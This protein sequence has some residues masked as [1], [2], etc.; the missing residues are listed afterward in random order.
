M[1]G[2]GVSIMQVGFHVSHGPIIYPLTYIRVRKA[3]S[4]YAFEGF[5]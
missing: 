4:I 1:T 3:L 5:V 2:N